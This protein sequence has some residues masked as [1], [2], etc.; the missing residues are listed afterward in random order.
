[1]VK[2]LGKPFRAFMFGGHSPAKKDADLANAFI[3]SIRRIR[4]LASVEPK[5]SVNLANH[6]HKNKL[7][8]KKEMGKGSGAI[9][10]FIDSKN[11][12][13]FLDMQEGIGLKKIEELRANAT[14]TD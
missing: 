8:E 7:F 5:V 13:D 1:M 12:F 4:K 14:K 6:P 3:D 11:F 2:N 9:N 10:Y